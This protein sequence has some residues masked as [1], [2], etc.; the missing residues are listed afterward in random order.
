MRR[1]AQIGLIALALMFV[2]NVDATAQRRGSKDKKETKKEEP[3][4]EDTNTTPSD[5]EK[6]TAKK[7]KT[8][9]S[10]TDNYFDESGGFKHRLQYGIH[11]NSGILSFFGGSFNLRLEPSAGYKFTNWAMAGLTGGIDYSREKG[12]QGSITYVAKQTAFN[13]GVYARLRPLAK[14]LPSIYI[15]S[16][17]KMVTGKFKYDE[18]TTG[19]KL[20]EKDT[21]RSEANVGIAYRS[22]TS[23]WAYE[24]MGV[25]NLNHKDGDPQTFSK[26][27]YSFRNTPFDLKIG[28]TYNF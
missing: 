27:A 1:I 12:S 2:F 13:Y 4:T 10:K 28:F 18:I 14:L 26:G 25:Y 17:Y 7:S 11:T 19:R 24:I 6:P 3:T 9:K 5:E 16:D 21:Y 15:H 8:T 22:G 20:D 23:S